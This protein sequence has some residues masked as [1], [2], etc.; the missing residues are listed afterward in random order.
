MDGE[1]P[2][3]R[4]QTDGD[5]RSPETGHKSLVL[6]SRYGAGS[7]AAAIIDWI[8]SVSAIQSTTQQPSGTRPQAQLPRTP[9][10]LRSL[11]TDFVRLKAR[12]CRAH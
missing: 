6:R 12:N 7:V 5:R 4:P 10:N 8:I 11:Q 2:Y 9:S 1:P 3:V